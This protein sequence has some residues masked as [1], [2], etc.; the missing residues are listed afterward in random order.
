MNPTPSSISIDD[1]LDYLDERAS[2][3]T[4]H[5]VESALEADSST[6]EIWEALRDSSSA[7]RDEAR[8]LHRLSPLSEQAVEAACS[9]VIAA[10][11][12]SSERV[13]APARLAQFELLLTPWCGRRV[14]AGLLLAAV[15]RTGAVSREKLWPSFLEQ[16]E[17]LTSCLCGG[18][19]ARLTVEFGRSLG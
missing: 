2:L 14:A 19:A 8:R 6:R 10:L 11:D 13:F 9:R 12:G 3:E 1:W 18:A 5:R 17:A 4:R 15:A 7:L 16:V